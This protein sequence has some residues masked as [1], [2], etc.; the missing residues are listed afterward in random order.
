MLVLTR[1]INQKV[2]I[3]ENII[4]EILE[5]DNGKIRLGITAP[6]NK[7]ILRSELINPADKL[8]KNNVIYETRH[9]GPVNQEVKTPYSN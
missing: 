2:H 4:I 9:P 7:L 6:E 5:I 8:I 3:A 1:T